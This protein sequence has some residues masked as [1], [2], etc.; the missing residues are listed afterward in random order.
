MR[1]YRDPALM[2]FVAAAY[3][4]WLGALSLVWELAQ[5]PLYTI[6]SEREWWYVAYAVAHCT[7]GD[8]V[9]GALSL[10]C[11]LVLTRAGPVRSWRTTRVA[12]ATAV[13]AV[14]YT[15]ASE[16]MNVHLMR[17]WN[18]APA[19]PLIDLGPFEIGLSPVVQWLVVVP[20]AIA[21]AVSNRGGLFVRNQW[22]PNR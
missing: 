3:L 20:S 2:R 15:V 22:R 14:A 19:M 12:V 21:L 6:V 4:P 18:Y 11:A 7:A 13:V 10:V 9:I 17:S 8:V 1:W 5:L 16:W